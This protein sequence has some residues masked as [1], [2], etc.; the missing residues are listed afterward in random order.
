MT[1]EER[2]ER[3]KRKIDESQESL[4]LFAK[5]YLERKSK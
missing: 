1:E 4:E 2:E 3:R 5:W